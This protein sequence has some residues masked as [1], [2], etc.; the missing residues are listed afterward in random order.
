MET[1]Q[2]TTVDLLVIGG[3]TGMA[4]VL[5]GHEAGLK[6][7]LVE[8]TDKL[9]GSTALS[10]GAFWVPGNAVLA[11]AGAADT[12]ERIRTYLKAVVDGSAPA[13]R[14]EA[15][16]KHGPAAVDM[17]RR[18]TPLD[19]M[20]SKGYSDYHPEEPGGS[21]AGRT[22]ES[23]PFDLSILGENRELL[24]GSGLKPPVPMPITGMDY[25]L[26]NLM[27]KL[28]FKAFPLIFRR[29]F[30]GLVG[31]VLFKKEYSAGGQALAGGLLAGVLRT[32]TPIWINTALKE[33]IVEDGRV[34]GAIVE[35]GGR[36]ITVQA[37][38]GVVLAAGGFDHNTEWRRK[39]QTETFQPSWTLGSPGNTGEAIEI[40]T[41][42]GAD[43]AG[44]E[45][46]WWFP[47][48][49][50][51]GNGKATVMLAERSL[52]GS[53]IVDESGKR[54]INE[55]C[56]YMTYGQIILQREQDGNP[57]GKTF[58][59]FDQEY[60]DSYVFATQ[61]FPK[62]PLPQKWYDEG[63]AFKGNTPA[64]L[65][66]AAGLPVDAV[67]D[68]FRNFNVMAA[69]GLDEDFH[70]GESAYD[71]YYGDPTVTP[72]PNLRPLSSGPFYA[73]EIVLGDLGT[74]GGV[75][76]DDRAR[77]L[78][79]DGSV[80]DGLYAIGNNAANAF[81]STY[82]GAGATIGQG[83]VYGYIAAR[84]AAGVL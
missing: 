40:A 71:R 27:R 65:A 69:N 68:T 82:P 59:V 17:L 4:A 13:E 32:N 42:N 39:Y 80:I 62:Q 43:L 37:T 55:S 15:F 19:L 81:G 47:A 78:R 58:I 10:G 20:W 76:A 3:G 23:K 22:C 34:T 61:V 60:R 12:T 75:V 25:R 31:K 8:K 21:P 38:K 36:E 46:V 44:M 74:C 50:P 30:K 64:E 6:T 41:N 7:L 24:R 2:D 72:N 1:P 53:F 51:I 77:A 57:V 45:N 29:V 49:A 11:E 63:I 66:R 33:L 48:V 9:G 83:V 73:V 35:N 5:A 14:S 70:R 26:M 56:D 52:P 54:F 16:V 67:E 18:T 79:A 84:D 28:P